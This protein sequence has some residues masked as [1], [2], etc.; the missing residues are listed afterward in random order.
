MH[1]IQFDLHFADYPASV[2]ACGGLPV[3]LTRDADVEDIVSRLDGLVLSGGA[4]VDPSR[5]GRSPDPNLGA[6]EPERD[7][8]E[9]ALLA[10][11]EGRG[12]PVLCVCRGVQL[13]NVARGG[14]LVQHVGVD[15][16]DGHPAFDADGHDAVHKVSLEP[17]TVAAG[18]FGDTI[19]VNSLHH[20]LI[21]DVGE[22][23][24]VSGRSPDGAIEALEETDRPILGVQWHPE[25]LHRPD[26]A[27]AWLVDACLQQASALR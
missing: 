11:A 26:P 15:E 20:Q 6:T 3:E 25:L 7:A 14:T 10:A 21:G 19:D 2:A 1:G 24:R 5:Y 8:W 13:L 18:L 22:G 4:D 23:L 12:I 27:F 9:L 16:G 17:G